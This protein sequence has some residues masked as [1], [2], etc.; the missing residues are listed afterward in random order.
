MTR[1]T[2]VWSGAGEATI[3]TLATRL[4]AGDAGL[5]LT[6]EAMDDSTT[7]TLRDRLAAIDRALKRLDDGYPAGL[8]APSVSE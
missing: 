5:Y 8:A 2:R 6:A 3:A 4:A 1:L 7:E